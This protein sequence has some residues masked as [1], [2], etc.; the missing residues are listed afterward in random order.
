MKMENAKIWRANRK[1]ITSAYSNTRIRNKKAKNE[2][3]TEKNDELIQSE[4]SHEI[5]EISAK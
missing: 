5:R 2:E 3:T 1:L 4:N